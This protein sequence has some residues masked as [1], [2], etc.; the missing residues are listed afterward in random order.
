MCR[1]REFGEQ[2]RSV[3]LSFPY[4]VDGSPMQV[5]LDIRMKLVNY[6]L[7]FA[8]NPGAQL[9]AAVE[10]KNIRLTA[11]AMDEAVAL[12]NKWLEDHPG[13]AL[14][15]AVKLDR[16]WALAQSGQML[17]ARAAYR[18]IA[19]G[20]PPSRE[21]YA[22]QMWLADQA[23][24]SKTNRLEAERGYLEIAGTTKSPPQLRQRALFMAGR[25]AMVRQGFEDA[26]K[27]FQDLLND[28][29]LKMS[30]RIEATFALGDLTP[31]ELGAERKL[32]AS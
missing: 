24:H 18:E 31:T 6:W 17:N 19:K 25:A 1:R 29:S 10:L 8:A 22:A 32:L 11:D 30:G 16:A 15:Q 5:A 9:L 12:Y 28:E 2:V 3:N 23:F 21:T 7:S 14:A 27:I 20:E 4:L 26:R 13:N